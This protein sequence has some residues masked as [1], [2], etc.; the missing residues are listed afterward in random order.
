MLIQFCPHHK[1]QPV[2]VEFEILNNTIILLDE[3]SID[4]Q[5]NDEMYLYI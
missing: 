3:D 5:L 1:R 2:Y 4:S